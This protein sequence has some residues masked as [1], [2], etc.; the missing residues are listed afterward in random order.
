MSK[1][2]FFD[3]ASLKASPMIVIGIVVRIS[4]ETSAAAM[5]RRPRKVPFPR[6]PSKPRVVTSQKTAHI[7]SNELT[8]LSSCGPSSPDEGSF[9]VSSP[10]AIHST[11][12]SSRIARSMA[13]AGTRIGRAA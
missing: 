12:D 3:Q 11:P 8:N 2:S 4:P 1:I 6:K 5:Q 7:V 9:E 10:S 13:N